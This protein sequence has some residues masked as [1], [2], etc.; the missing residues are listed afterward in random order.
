M[1]FSFLDGHFP[2][3]SIKH[4]EKDGS[5]WVYI[6]HPDYE[7]PIKVDYTDDMDPPYL[8]RFSTQHL[9][10]AT[11]EE[12]LAHAH[13]FATGQRAAMEFYQDGQPCFGGDEAVAFIFYA[14]YDD[15]L[16]R[17]RVVL[18]NKHTFRCYGWHPDAMVSGRFERDEQRQWQVILERN[19]P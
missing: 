7:E 12:V 2:G 6:C 4:F 16:R 15:W 17:F 14:G 11:P 18:T 1:H 10:L 8:L 19:E 13:A 3:C 9:H 5:E